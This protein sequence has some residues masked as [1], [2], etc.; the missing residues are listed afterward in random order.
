[1]EKVIVSGDLY[2]AQN[3]AWHGN[4]TNTVEEFLDNGNLG[5]EEAVDKFIAAYPDLWHPVSVY[6]LMNGNEYTMRELL[7]GY[8]ERKA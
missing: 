8:L 3:Q 6:E 4:V 5:I 2:D 1:M 7:V